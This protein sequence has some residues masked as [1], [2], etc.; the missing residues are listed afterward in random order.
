M[1]TTSA[2]MKNILKAEKVFKEGGSFEEVLVVLEYDEIRDLLVGL[3]TDKYGNMKRLTD[4]EDNYLF[5]RWD[6]E[7]LEKVDV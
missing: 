2:T 6:L 1:P 7:T 5:G 3:L 4:Q